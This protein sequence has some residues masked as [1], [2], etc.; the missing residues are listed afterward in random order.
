MP[1]TEG[2][3]IA[4]TFTRVVA[5]VADLLLLGAIGLI[6]DGA[7]GLFEVGRDANVALLVGGVLVGVDFLYFV[8]LW[9]SGL[10]ATLGMRMLRL[11]VVAAIL[12]SHHVDQRR[13]PA[14]AGAERRG[15]DPD[16]RPRRERVHRAR[17][18]SSGWSSCWAR[19]R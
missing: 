1:V 11:R 13:R 16:P 17:C 19:P 15:R 3:V 4:G 2:L 7:L 14:L 5:Y 10:Q 8:G 18:R 9:T 12:G 6:V